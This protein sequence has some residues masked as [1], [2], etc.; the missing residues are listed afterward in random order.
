M[1]SDW[2][3]AA[4]CTRPTNASEAAGTSRVAT[5]PSEGSTGT[6]SDCGTSATPERTGTPQPGS[7]AAATEDTTIA[8]TRP[9]EPSRVR[10]SS[11]IMARVAMVTATVGQWKDATWSSVSAARSSRLGAGERYPV[12]P[13][14]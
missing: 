12:A 10:S 11:R 2:L 13:A 8:T 9:S 6:G 1:G 14:S 7:S 4:P 5:S 3:I